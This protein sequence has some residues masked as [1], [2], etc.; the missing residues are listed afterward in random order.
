MD[1][2]EFARL[3]CSMGVTE[4]IDLSKATSHFSRHFFFRSI[5]SSSPHWAWNPGAAHSSTQWFRACYKYVCICSHI[6][7]KNGMRSLHT[8]PLYYIILTLTETEFP[9]FQSE[10]KEISRCWVMSQSYR[11]WHSK[12]ETSHSYSKNSNSTPYTIPAIIV[13]LH[14]CHIFISYT[15]IILHLAYASLSSISTVLLH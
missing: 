6:K 15:T 5:P 1:G 12:S 10:G 13:K 8:N 3:Y 9:V 11:K 14:S 2:S 7:R 4:S